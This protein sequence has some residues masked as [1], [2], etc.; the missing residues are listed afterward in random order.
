[1]IS[2]HTDDAAG[3]AVSSSNSAA[4]A[5]LGFSGTA[6][7]VTPPLR[8]GPNTTTATSSGATNQATTPG[9]VTGATLLSGALGSDSIGA[10]FA[11]NDTI[12]VNGTAITFV[13]A[14]A[15]GNQLNI[16]DSIQ[17]LLSKIDS[18]SG[19]S[20]PSSISGG[21]IS[22]HANNGSGLRW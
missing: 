12:T 4:F 16:G 18:L 14:G 20:T 8:I 2:I 15:T 19:T 1:M 10:S 17:S 22:L 13:A 6:T 21:V 9:P 11:V 5:A 3:L 7:A